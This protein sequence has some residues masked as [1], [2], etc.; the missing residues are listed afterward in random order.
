MAQLSRARG[1]S[2][3]PSGKCA[4]SRKTAKKWIRNEGDRRAVG[5]GCWFDEEAAERAAGWIETYLRHGK[6][7]WDGQ[8]FMLAPWQRE[9]IIYPLFG[10]KRADGTRRFR[11]GYIEIPRKNGK[12]TL[13]AAIAAYLL[14]GDGEPGAEI[15][16]A[17]VDREQASIVFRK[18]KEMVEVSPD[19]RR[20]C[21]IVKHNISVHQTRSFYRPLSAD[22]PA[23]EGL[24]AYG[25]IFDE[26]HAQ[27]GREL[28]DTLKTSTGAREQPLLLSITTAG[29]NQDSLCWDLHEYARQVVEGLIED[30]SFFALV[31][32][33]PPEADWTDPETWRAANPSLGVTLKEEDI[34]EDCRRARN[35]PSYQNTFRRYRLNQWTQQE[36][37][38][39][40]MD[41]WARCGGSLSDEELRDRSC[42]GG[43]DLSSTIDLTALALVWALGDGRY[44]LR[45]WFWVPAEGLLER[46]RRDRVP[47]E[48]WVRDGWIEATPGDVV[49]YSFIRAKI[50]ELAAVHHPAEIAYDPWNSRYLV[51]QLQEEDGLTMIEM[52]QGFA[53]MSG[54]AKEFERLVTDGRMRHGDN[55]VL[56]WMADNVTVQSDPAGN[57]K[58]K[59]PDRSRGGKRIDGIT[60]AVMALG[61]AAAGAGTRRSY[62]EDHGVE[63]I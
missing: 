2:V 25:I 47:Y 30:D 54:P 34:A 4:S 36:T 28:Y 42:W 23:Q 15:Y 26:V 37:R 3:Q 62:Y 20:I 31:Y 1:K 12:S 35:N 60:A 45:S 40:P 58:P 52:R 59:K 63:M 39:I 13:A 48:A 24:N 8:P 50:K 38:W 5:R 33:A 44:G 21:T 10:W 49:D 55:P 9:E 7:R 46:G 17:A 53:S 16:S 18:V 61:R 51:T 29:V 14:V 27:R 6:G 56:R 57:I 43:L 19:L 32:A 11:E 22:A 41:R